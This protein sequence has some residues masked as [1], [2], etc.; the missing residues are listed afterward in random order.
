MNDEPR[1]TMKL[2]TAKTGLTAHAIRVWEKRY[3]AVSPRRTA[4]NRRL[5]SDADVKKLRLLRRASQAG[6][7]IGQIASLPPERLADLVRQEEGSGSQGALTAS[8]RREAVTVD[9]LLSAALEAALA[10]DVRGLEKL[11]DQAAALLS[12]PVLF[13]QLIVP[14]LIRLGDL[15][16]EGT[17]RI[18]HEHLASAAIRTFVGNLMSASRLRGA[19]PCLVVATPAGHLH[20]FGALVA[21]ATATASG[22]RAIYLGPDL[23]AEEIAGAALQN[24]ARVVAV[25]LVYPPDDA[26]LAAELERLHRYLPPDTTLLVG[27]RAAR[28]YSETLERIGAITLPDML[29]LRGKLQELHSPREPGP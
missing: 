24:Q 12:Q 20:E 8:P 9:S 2:V 25:S 23:P 27:G 15:W 29:S 6:Y 7:S 16:Q 5:Y 19:E 13:D 4:S 18:A 28:G 14:F 22:W 21:A 1:Y 26:G 3:R 10:M 11:L 17:M